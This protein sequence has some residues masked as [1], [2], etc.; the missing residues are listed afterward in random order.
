MRR[1]AGRERRRE[2]RKP[3]TVR[4]LAQKLHPDKVAQL[5]P[6]AVQLATRAFTSVSTAYEQ[7]R[8][9]RGF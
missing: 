9:E 7:I 8:N 5:G 3:M 6:E 2:V 4:A 1:S